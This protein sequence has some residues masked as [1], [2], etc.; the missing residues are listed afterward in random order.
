MMQKESPY[1]Q[2]IGESL[3]GFMPKFMKGLTI[4]GTAAMFTVGGPMVAHA[5]GSM[6]PAVHHGLEVVT[7]FGGNSLTILVEVGVGMVAS[8]G[9]VAAHSPTQKLMSKIK[10]VFRKWIEVIY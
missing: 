6:L 2:K 7:T 8:F 4:V 10:S 5:L 9:V 1:M 3:V